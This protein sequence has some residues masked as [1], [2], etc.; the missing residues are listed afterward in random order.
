MA[1]RMQS[2][3]SETTREAGTSNGARQAP[4]D[5]RNCTPPTTQ[6]PT[7]RAIHPTRHAAKTAYCNCLL[8]SS[9]C[10]RRVLF[11]VVVVDNM[12]HELQIKQMMHHVI[13]YNAS[14]K[15]C[16]CKHVEG[17]PPGISHRRSEVTLTTL[18]FTTR[19]YAMHTMPKMLDAIRANTTT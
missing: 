16:K 10:F 5:M 4:G 17:C 7:K 2:A 19:R 8:L 11:V 1:R 18:P 9:S 6:L 15:N 14:C 3:I 12:M 13:R